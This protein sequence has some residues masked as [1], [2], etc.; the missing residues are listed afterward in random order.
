M[1]LI[2]KY[3]HE[4]ITTQVLFKKD[5]ETKQ[6]IVCVGCLAKY[7]LDY[8]KVDISQKDVFFTSEDFWRGFGKGREMKHSKKMFEKMS[9]K[10]KLAFM[11]IFGVNIENPH[12][13]DDET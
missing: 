2:C 6:E 9:K 7:L 4:E 13:F 1:K 12:Y 10:E 8:H 11:R 5:G 3:C